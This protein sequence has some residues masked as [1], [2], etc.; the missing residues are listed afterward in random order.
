M[1]FD[2]T[3]P[4][5]MPADG[6]RRLTPRETMQRA[7]AMACIQDKDRAQC[8]GQVYATLFFDG[9]GNNKDWIEP[10]LSGTQTAVNRHS[11]VARLYNACIDKPSEGFYS[12]YM[13]GVGTPFTEI[14][15]KSGSVNAYLG[16]GCGYMGADRI[17]WGI[18]RVFNAVH[19]YLTDQLLLGDDEAKKLVNY[20]SR[21]LGKE[22]VAEFEWRLKMGQL[23][24]RLIPVIGGNQRNLTQINI[25]VFGFSRGAA[26]A[27]VFANWLFGRW[28]SIGRSA[29]PA[30]LH[31]LV[32]F[33][34]LGGRAG[35]YSGVRWPY[36]LG[37]RLYG[38]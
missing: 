12:Y 22:V 32:R 17:N 9:S 1:S 16:N 23:R 24:D 21:S 31:G 29:D 4:Q 2:V 33:G 18:T 30:L 36:G 26:E 25:A 34:S 11:N 27:R 10:G 14:G 35:L 6:V 28:P 37:G 15:D 19:H 5:P 20:V 13:P 8:Q 38:D 3:T 7:R